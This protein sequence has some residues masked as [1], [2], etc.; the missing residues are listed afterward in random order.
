MIGTYKLLI[1]D[2]VEETSDITTF[3]LKPPINHCDKFTYKP[4]QYISV[5]YDKNTSRCYSLSSH[6]DEDFLS[7][8]V[9]RK[10]GGLISNYL[11]NK[12]QPGDYLDATPPTGNF[13]NGHESSTEKYVFIAAGSGVVPIFSILKEILFSTDKQI[14]LSYSSK[15]ESE[16]AFR[17]TL[18]EWKK[19]YFS[20]LNIEWIFTKKE[21]RLNEKAVL[22]W[23]PTWD[24]KPQTTEFYLCGPKDF[25]SFVK[26]SLP[27]HYKNIYTESFEHKTT[28]VKST[29]NITLSHE[30]PDESAKRII[31][32]DATQNSHRIEAIPGATILE[33]A[34]AAG[35]DVPY[36]C[37]SGNCLAC[38]AKL[39]EGRV[40]MR[41]DTCIDSI[42]LANKQILT[43]QSQC[44]SETVSVSFENN[45]E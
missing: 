5:F 16:A 32:T 44:L 30:D 19:I 21:G 38:M 9:K 23:I 11:L 33:S 2:K 28:K 27:P 25:M 14:F 37:L 6:P 31:I 39:T 10:K 12:K 13:F 1:H 3:F 35:L 43:C 7:I 45:Y 34:M 22:N 20:R 4:A 8:T 24:L 36:S 41:P 18:L 42:D 40:V 29:A 26:K 17:D 15:K